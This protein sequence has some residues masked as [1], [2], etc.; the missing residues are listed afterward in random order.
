[1]LKLFSYK[2][3]HDSGFAP[4]PFWGEL[5]LATCKPQIRLHKGKGDW[6]AGFTSGELC[7]DSVGGEKLVFLMK[8]EDK[9]SIVQYFSS[10]RYKN[11]IPDPTHALRIRQAGDNI[12]YQTSNGA[13][14]QL[15]NAN[16]DCGNMADDLSG[17]FVLTATEFVYFGGEAISIP[18]EIRPSVPTGQSRHGSQTHDEERARQFLE[19]VFT[20]FRLGVQGPPHMWPA[21]D[22][23]WKQTCE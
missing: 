22:S 8:V 10:P 13:Y 3:T 16:H 23:S 1:M 18:A 20:N 4:N 11:K 7:G 17:E 6:I 2:M 9:L 19:Y 21:D 12:Y 5:T 14:E 15:E